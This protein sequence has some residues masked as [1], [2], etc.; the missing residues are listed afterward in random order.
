V[1]W[2]DW[3]NLETLDLA[4]VGSTCGALGRRRARARETPGVRSGPRRPAISPRRLKRPGRRELVMLGSGQSQ[5]CEQI[6]TP[7]CDS[8]DPWVARWISSNPIDVTQVSRKALADLSLFSCII[9]EDLPEYLPLT[10]HSIPTSTPRKSVSSSLGI[11]SISCAHW[12]APISRG[13]CSLVWR[14][15]IPSY[16]TIHETRS[17]QTST[18]PPRQNRKSLSGSGTFNLPCHSQLSFFSQN[19]QD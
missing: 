7:R 15:Q 17:Y 6:W 11:Y 13:Y 9:N 19:L 1:K 14:N 10:T 3:G 12:P 18:C 4:V 2:G 16:T 8:R 5:L